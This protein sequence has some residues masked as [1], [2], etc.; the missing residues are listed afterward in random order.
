MALTP[1]KAFSP[2]P[3]RMDIVA[4]D[5][6]SMS[7]Q[8]NAESD[9]L[10]VVVTGEFSLEEAKRTFLQMLEAI[11]LHK[12]KKVLLDGREVMGNPET[13]E[14]FYY[15]QFAA[16]KVVAGKRGVPVATR[17]AYVLREPLR[18]PRRFGE[19]VAVN[20]GMNVKTFHNPEEAFQW[21]KGVES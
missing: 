16:Q 1:E 5:K 13:M 20:R 6:M 10:N 19:T 17:F 7:L 8:M 18:D 15:G 4:A 14:R 11:V 9:L 2:A 21:L 12:S 3:L